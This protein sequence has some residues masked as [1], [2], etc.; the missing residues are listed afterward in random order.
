MKISEGRLRKIILEESRRIL[1]ESTIPLR[2]SPPAHGRVLHRRK[3]PSTDHFK[4]NEVLTLS[5]ISAFQLLATRARYLNEN[6]KG[7]IDWLALAIKMMES[8]A[9][10]RI[11]LGFFKL[12]KKITASREVVYG[13]IRAAGNKAIEK[14][15]SYGIDVPFTAENMVTMLKWIPFVGFAGTELLD[16]TLEEAVKLLDG[17]D[18]SEFQQ[19]SSAAVA[20]SSAARAAADAKAAAEKADNED[21]D[22]AE[23][24]AQAE[25]EVIDLRHRRRRQERTRKKRA[26][27]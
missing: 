14:L 2:G 11:F 1:S 4:L 3:V 18:D 25:T 23:D 20:K 24:D 15:K 26:A 6:K 19:L 12:L 9:A 16:M 22:D 7:E 8:K 10:R 13:A 27:A 17:M 5:E 21:D